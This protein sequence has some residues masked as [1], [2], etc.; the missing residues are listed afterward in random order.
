M[1]W[2]QDENEAAGTLRVLRVYV[3]SKFDEAEPKETER[4]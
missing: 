3:L 2:G 1:T 4:V